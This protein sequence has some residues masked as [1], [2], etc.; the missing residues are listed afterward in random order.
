MDKNVLKQYTDYMESNIDSDALMGLRGVQSFLKEFDLTI[1]QVLLY[2]A[3]NYQNIKT[4]E[5]PV[6]EEAV[7]VVP[8]KN[9]VRV[10]GDIPDFK[11]HSNGVIQ[12]IFPDG[13]GSGCTLPVC[14]LNDVGD[15]A[16]AM[17]DAVVA[18]II[19]KAHIKIKLF[20][21]KNDEGK[22]VETILRTE[23]DREGMQPIDLWHG[24]K[25]DAGIVASVL[26]TFVK[27]AVPEL[28]A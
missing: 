12:V 24:T 9:N 13:S 14:A 19:N 6:V 27:E 18:A 7:S 25:G 3:D 16:V 1:E 5:Q 10:A 21:V 28:V 26:R 11:S 17:K 4:L 8:S 22:V 20:D 2:V 23:Y 15:I